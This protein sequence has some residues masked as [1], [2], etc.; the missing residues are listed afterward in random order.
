[1]R[2]PL[3]GRNAAAYLDNRITNFRDQSA[4]RAS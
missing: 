4:F 3:I 2:L 1:M